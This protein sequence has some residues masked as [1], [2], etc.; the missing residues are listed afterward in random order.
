MAQAQ[1]RRAIALFGLGRIGDARLVL[2]WVRKLNE[3]EKGLG[4]WVESVRKAYEALDDEV[5]AKKTVIEEWPDKRIVE[6]VKAALDGGEAT[7][8]TTESTPKEA[9]YS[10]SSAPEVNKTEPVKPQ[11][12]QAKPAQAATPAPTS[13]PVARPAI[14]PT[15]RDK[16]RHEWYQSSASVSISILAKG[17]PKD[18]AWVEISP[19]RVTVSFPTPTGP[20]TFTIF[21]TYGPIDAEKSSYNITQHKLELTLKKEGGLKWAKL[22]GDATATPTTSAAAAQP[23]HLPSSSLGQDH[24]PAY[25]TSSKHGTKDWD[26]LAKEELK[27][28]NAELAASN[29][30]EPKLDDDK[31]ADDDDD[32]SDPLHGFFKKIYK[33]ADPDT[34]RAMMKSFTE[35]QGTELSTDWTKVGKE[36]VDVK[37]P[38][39]YEEKEF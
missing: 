8:D 12:T 1:M 13:E 6:E 37:A 24:A 20:F 5:E 38:E 39:G 28:A 19:N 36:K 14:Q 31:A 33:G 15:P 27:K 29:G 34:K 7:L 26:A 18:M 32:E 2:T 22:E 25:P 11:T 4:M 21:P 10:A 16:I 23:A 35:S 17:I 3:K 30:A 9:T